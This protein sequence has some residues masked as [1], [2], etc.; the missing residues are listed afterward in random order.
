MLSF[1]KAAS[2]LQAVPSAVS[3]GATRLRVK[4]IRL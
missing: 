3:P 1:Q 4:K 2:L